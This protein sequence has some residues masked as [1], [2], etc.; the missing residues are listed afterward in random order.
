MNIQPHPETETVYAA[1]GTGAGL[2]IAPLVTDRLRGETIRGAVAP[3]QGWVSY[4]SGQKLA[5]PTLRYRQEG[6]VP[7]RFCTVVYPHPTQRRASVKVSPLD[8]E[9][10]SGV[11]VGSEITGLRVE[12]EAHVDY[13]IVDRGARETRKAFAG[14]ETDAQLLYI[15]HD[16]GEM[17]PEKVAMRG[18]RRLLFRGRSLLESQGLGKGFS[19][20]NDG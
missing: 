8:V 5:A 20:D 17:D 1:N 14:Y 11:P 16:K 13:L 15:R 2:T 10:G 12:T 9:T 18:G 4:L 3:I 6:P 19:L 7:A